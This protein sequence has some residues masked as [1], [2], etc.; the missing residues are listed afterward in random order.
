M[1]Y[2]FACCWPC[3]HI[4]CKRY[5]HSARL[6]TSLILTSRQSCVLFIYTGTGSSQEYI[7]WGVMYEFVR[8]WLYH[9]NVCKRY[10]HSANLVSSWVLMSRQ[11][12]ILFIYTRTGSW[13]DYICDVMYTFVNF[14]LYHYSI[15]YR[16]R[17]Q[18]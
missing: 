10:D 7:L 12:C 15:R 17:P 8:F 13:Q 5:D 4:V 11:S 16:V 9:H 1:V 2:E 6:V 18:C 3:H 14:W